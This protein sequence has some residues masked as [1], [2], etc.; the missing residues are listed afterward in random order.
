MSGEHYCSISEVWLVFFS[1][2]GV[3]KGTF[4]L[5][6]VQHV[7]LDVVKVGHAVG[8]LRP[9]LVLLMFER[10]FEHVLM[11]I[12]TAGLRWKVSREHWQ[13]FSEPWLFTTHWHSAIPCRDKSMPGAVFVPGAGVAITTP[14]NFNSSKERAG[15]HN[16]EFKRVEVHVFYRS[17]CQ[18]PQLFW[19]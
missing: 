18:H 13:S 7:Q 6:K 19:N 2:F 14:S 8:A 9:H 16:H 5:G 15:F 10:K 1:S 11:Q 12:I 3:R 4:F 17:L